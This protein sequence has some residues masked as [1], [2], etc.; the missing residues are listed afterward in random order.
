[1]WLC[2]NERLIFDCQ[3]MSEHSKVQD[4]A[5]FIFITLNGSSQLGQLNIKKQTFEWI[6]GELVS[7]RDLSFSPSHSSS[8]THRKQWVEHDSWFSE[9]WEWMLK[10]TNSFGSIFHHSETDLKL[11]SRTLQTCK[12]L[13]K[14]PLSI[15]MDESGHGQTEIDLNLHNSRLQSAQKSLQYFSAWIS[16]LRGC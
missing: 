13:T 9:P 3:N 8:K 10:M 16:Y 14:L 6:E 2:P 1:M 11:D 7:I 5:K 4:A 12:T 15:D